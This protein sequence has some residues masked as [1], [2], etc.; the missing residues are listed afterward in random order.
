[1]AGPFDDYWSIV[2]QAIREGDFD[3]RVGPNARTNNWNPAFETGVYGQPEPQ[4]LPEVDV[5]ATAYADARPPM[6][7]AQAYA[8][9]G[10]LSQG[11]SMGAG[12]A[13]GGN[14][15][16]WGNALQGAGAWLMAHDTGG[17]SLGVLDTLMRK[18]ALDK[19][20]KGD[21][22]GI[23]TLPDGTAFKLNKKTGEYEQI[24]APVPKVVDIGEG[25]LGKIKGY[26]IGPRVFDMSGRQ[27][28]GPGMQGGGQGMQ[29]PG[30]GGY[31]SP[32]DLGLQ[33]VLRPNTQYD[34]SLQGA[35]RLDQFKPEIKQTIID[36]H[37]GRVAIPQR[38]DKYSQWL[39]DQASRYGEEIGDPLD[40]NRFAA[41]RKLHTELAGGTAQST[42]GQVVGS[43]TALDH[44]G[45]MADSYVAV[46]NRSAWPVVGAIPGSNAVMEG[47]NAVGNSKADAALVVKGLKR[48][49]DVYGQ[50]ATKMLAG[51]QPAQA[52][53]DR[54]HTTFHENLTPQAAYGSLKKDRDLMVDRFEQN[55]AKV[56]A[57]YGKN[58]PET[59]K[60]RAIFTKT[61]ERLDTKLQKLAEAAGLSTPSPRKI[62][63]VTRED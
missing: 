21:R 11:G 33:P 14:D 63:G 53:R 32:T 50:E 29:S 39:R 38:G 20:I 3:P 35:A 36:M 2:Q 31:G 18:E 55:M 27:V 4:K 60:Q 13:A 12:E 19:Q 62:M 25:P 17:K 34:D 54:I 16:N 1:M 61:L 47:V 28:F 9:P 44:L 45:E 5:P 7:S 10:M 51:G 57:V 8:G 23:S 59:L 48:N 58:D 15:F 30:G 41:R 46:K 42:G 40:T 43:R 37:A 24:A 6:L 56:E 49:I 22:F 26:Q 52:E